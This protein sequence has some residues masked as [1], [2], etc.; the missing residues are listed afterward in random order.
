[1][2]RLQTS[3]FLCTCGSSL[4]QFLDYDSLVKDLKSAPDI[5][6]IHIHPTLCQSEGLA[7]I[8]K[9]AREGDSRAT[10]VGACSKRI[11][12]L[13]SGEMGRAIL[14][15]VS[16][17]ETVNIREHCAWVHPVREE[18]TAKAKVLVLAAARRAGRLQP[19]RSKKLK[20]EERVLVIGGGV[21]GIQAALDLA[22]LGF[23]T[24]LVE[25]SPTIGGKMALLVKTYP[26]DDCAICILGP[27]M[28]DVAAHPLIHLVTYSEVTKVERSPEKFRVTIRKNPRYVDS[29]KCTACGICAEK[30]PVKVPSEWNGG[31]GYRKAAYLPYPQAIP[32]KYLIDAANCLFTQKGVCRVCE[33]FCPAGATN[34]DEKPEELHLD[35]GAIV[36]ATG[37]D[38]FDPSQLRQLGFGRYEDVVTQ[39][40]LARMLDPSGPTEGKLRRPSNSAKPKRIVMIQCVGSRDPE[41]NRYC[42]RYCCMAAMKNAILI[43]VEQDPEAEITILYKDVRAAGKGFEEYYSKA[44]DRFGI[45]FAKGEAAEVSRDEASGKL[46]VKYV[47]PSGEKQSLSCDL[48][49]L[50]CAMVPP[51][52]SKELAEAI[53]LRL[54]E[55]GFVRELD[56]KV[57][58]TETNVPGVYVCGVS[59]GPK[60]IPESVA[61][62]SAAAA[63]A[64]RRMRMSVVKPVLAPSVSAEKCGKCGL[65]I[66][67]CPYRAIRILGDKVDIDESLCTGC[68]LCVTACGTRALTPQLLGSEGLSEHVHD[69]V[70]DLPDLLRPSVLAFACEE[71]GYTV[72]DNAGFLRQHY[73]ANVVPVVVPCMSAVSV[74]HIAEAMACGA[75]GVIALGCSEARCHYEKGDRVAKARASLTKRILQQARIDDHNVTVLTLPGNMSQRFSETA[76]VTV[77]QLKGSRDVK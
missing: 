34:L 11:Y 15:K 19:I 76:S 55:D 38:E 37:F 68:G 14:E 61:Q 64:A 49:V 9:H 18:A 42:S 44:K 48:A 75:A 32:R 40:Q 56:E 66:S 52:G 31:L 1:M 45:R 46:A 28:A 27:K 3:A 16:P 8:E 39:F 67:V 63:K 77:R 69:I 4:E 29:A 74:N 30:C 57:C 73:P 51:A 54:S 60:D 33:K 47:S 17:V 53:G 20:V 7:F 22:Q 43:K 26:T 5:S 13:I 12:D 21:A 10:V 25:R 65:C 59:Q 70:R 71:C 50:S 36:V 6:S 72:L 35:L 24:Y 62:A 23:E 41:T 58:T 2:S